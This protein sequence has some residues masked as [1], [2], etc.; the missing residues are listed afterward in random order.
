MT[1]INPTDIAIT[2][3]AFA[4]AR[5]YIANSDF[6][7]TNVSFVI[8]GIL[9]EWNAGELVIP[10][11]VELTNIVTAADIFFRADTD[12]ADVLKLPVAEFDALLARVIYLLFC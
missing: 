8:N 5:S 3:K 2:D 6:G 9:F 11:P 12:C 1:H 4:N 10:R 7:L